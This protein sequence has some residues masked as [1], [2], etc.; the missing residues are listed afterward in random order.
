MSQSGGRLELQSPAE[1]RGDGF[2][3]RLVLAS[4]A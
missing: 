2:E 4:T 3:A 1:G